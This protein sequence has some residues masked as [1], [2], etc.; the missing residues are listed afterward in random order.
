M[1]RVAL[2]SVAGSP[3]TSV[4][5][6]CMRRC[7]VRSGCVLSQFGFLRLAWDF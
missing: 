1:V 7:P 4:V 3:L 2:R 6:P 5:V